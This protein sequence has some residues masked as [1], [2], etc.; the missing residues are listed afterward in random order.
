MQRIVR[1]DALHRERRIVRKIRHFDLPVVRPVEDVDEHFV[2]VVRPIIPESVFCEV[3]VAGRRTEVRFLEQTL[4]QVVSAELVSGVLADAFV[5]P[6][7][8]A[9]GRFEDLV[10]SGRPVAADMIAGVIGVPRPP[11]CSAY[12][13]DIVF[14]Q[15]FRFRD[16]EIVVGVSRENVHVVAFQTLHETFGILHIIACSRAAGVVEGRSLVQRDVHPD[17][18]RSLL[19]HCRE[20]FPQ[21]S[22]FFIR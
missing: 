14:A 9:A 18:D 16:V 20:V 22:E 12:G 21:P 15:A 3:G 17:E 10:S 2:I 1:T 11:P 6:A 5:V 13:G 7:Y 4:V 19:V 8:V